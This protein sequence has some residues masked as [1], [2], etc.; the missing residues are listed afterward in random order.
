MLNMDSTCYT[1]ST[2]ADANITLAAFSG[3][4]W[5]IGGVAWSYEGGTLYT[6]A[7]LI[8]SRT[9]TTGA[10]F[11]DVHINDDGAGFVIPAET[12]K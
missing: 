1:V 7:A 10:I 2:A 5:S 11:L 3:Q 6:D 9:D 12:I 8:I 4:R